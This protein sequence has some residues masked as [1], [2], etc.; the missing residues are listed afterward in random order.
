[1]A[2]DLDEPLGLCSPGVLAIRSGYSKPAGPE[3]VM[4]QQDMIQ[5]TEGKTDP[6]FA[7]THA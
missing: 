5:D 7:E 3:G 6:I 1:M 2:Q 4:P